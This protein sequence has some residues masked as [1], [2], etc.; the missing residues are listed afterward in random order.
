MK[1]TYIIGFALSYTLIANAHSETINKVYL[2]SQRNVHIINMHGRDLRITN[3]GNAGSLKLSPDRLT[4]AWL[5]MNTW[6]A[7]GDDEPSSEELVI[8][9]DG[10]LG[11]LKCTPFIRDYWFWKNGS[12]VAIDC[13]GRRF[14]G[15]ETLYDTKTMRQLASFDEAEVPLEKRP[16]WSDANN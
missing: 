9:R 4:V 12:Q 14:A 1:S 7:E 3:E 6:T 2:D 15:S 16:D 8:Y 11:S 10:K 13:G 5:V